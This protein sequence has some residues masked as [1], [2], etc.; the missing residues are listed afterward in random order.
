MAILATTWLKMSI[1]LILWT[2]KGYE[3]MVRST[4]INIFNDDLMILTET[5]LMAETDI[6][7]YYSHHSLVK[8]GPTGRPSG[9]ISCFLK[10]SLTPVQKIQATLNQRNKGQQADQMEEFHAF[11]SHH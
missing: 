9:G 7:G 10:A 3:S 4:P 11:S 8:Q 1:Q 5:F 2:I 6:Q